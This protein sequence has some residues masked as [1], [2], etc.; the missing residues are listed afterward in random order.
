[1]TASMTGQT[2]RLLTRIER[3]QLTFH[4]HHDEMDQTLRSLNGMG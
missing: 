2:Q 4:V 1:M 3:N